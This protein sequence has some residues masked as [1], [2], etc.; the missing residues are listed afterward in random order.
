MCEE[1]QETFSLKST[2]R[3][4]NQLFHARQQDTA[5]KEQFDEW[6]FDYLLQKNG[7][8]K[9]AEKFFKKFVNALLSHSQS[10]PR[11]QLFARFMQL[12]DAL[13]SQ[14]L[15]QYFEV[16]D[17]AQKLI[18]NFNIADGDEQPM[19]PLKRGIEILK[20]IYPTSHNTKSV[21]TAIRYLQAQ[22]Y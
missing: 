3:V 12:G 15:N 9:S 14:H 1:P 7:L 19:I 8:Q 13:S 2:L 5:T 16:V 18:K 6:V 22:S 4:I 10:S 20:T 11:I 17:H 21:T